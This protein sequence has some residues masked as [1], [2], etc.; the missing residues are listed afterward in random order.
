MAEE[1]GTAQEGAKSELADHPAPA[2]SAAPPPKKR[3]S[4]WDTAPVESPA[5]EAPAAAGGKSL[6]DYEQEWQQSGGTRGA[7]PGF[8][9]ASGQTAPPPAD[10]QAAYV[11]RREIKQPNTEQVAAASDNPAIRHG[12]GAEEA[13]KDQVLSETIQ[14]A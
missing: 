5:A 14:S 11:P 10:E 13:A 2:D 9:P 6:A 1:A 12:I 7:M 4:A 3:R 8:V